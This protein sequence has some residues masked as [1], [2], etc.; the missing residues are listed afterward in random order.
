MMCLA[1]GSELQARNIYL[2]TGG[3]TLWNKDGAAFFVH[4]WGGAAE[5]DMKMTAKDGDIYEADVPDDNKSIIYHRL[6]RNRRHLVSLR[7]KRQ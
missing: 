7:T 1:A 3:T 5:A 6:G 4:S 2:H